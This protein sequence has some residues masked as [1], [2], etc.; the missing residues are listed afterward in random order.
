MRGQYLRAVAMT[1]SLLLAGC[2]VGPDY[3]RPETGLPATFIEPNAPGTVA[4]DAGVPEQWWKLYNDPVLDA[5]VADGLAYNSEVQAAVA[6]P[7]AW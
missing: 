5:L 6:M 4:G 2:M 7:P 1:A 3:K